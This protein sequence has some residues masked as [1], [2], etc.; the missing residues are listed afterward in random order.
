MTDKKRV[1]IAQKNCFKRP[2]GNAKRSFNLQTMKERHHQIVRYATLGYKNTEIAQKLGITPQS[3]GQVLSSPIVQIK[4]EVI[5]GAKDAK[6]VK[7]LEDIT[8]ILPDA[9]KLLKNVVNEGELFEGEEYSSADRALQVK[10]SKDL[11]GIGGYS[12][13][14]R[15]ENRNVTAHLTSDEVAQMVAEAQNAGIATG[16]IIDVEFDSK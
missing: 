12:P 16:D 5:C 6:T 4:R 2:S 14:K 15:S 9:V 7:I 11:L 1:G 10:A 3:V 8:D 13:V